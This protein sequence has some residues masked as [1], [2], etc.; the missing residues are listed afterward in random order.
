MFN[1]KVISEAPFILVQS[2]INT[3]TSIVELTINSESLC[4]TSGLSVFVMQANSSSGHIYSAKPGI[5]PGHGSSDLPPCWSLDLSSY[6]VLCLAFSTTISI[7]CSGNPSP[8]VL[9]P[10]KKQNK[11]TEFDSEWSSR[12]FP[13]I[14]LCCPASYAASPLNFM[15]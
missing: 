8:W 10:R 9:I 12:G 1:K 3:L 14:H 13:Q 4:L 11:E 2:H 15:V 5:Q 6:G 7:Y